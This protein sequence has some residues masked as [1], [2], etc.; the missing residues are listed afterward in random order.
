MCGRALINQL[1]KSFKCLAKP[2]ANFIIQREFTFK[3]CFHKS[4]ILQ[5]NSGALDLSNPALETHLRNT[6][7]NIDSSSLNPN[8]RAMLIHLWSTRKSLQDDF[9]Q[10]EKELSKGM[11]T[12]EK[13]IYISDHF[14]SA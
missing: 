14:L 2:T 4:H 6:I 13:S 8:Q 9:Q 10:L 12:I 7:E 5:S 1:S 3:R 11:F